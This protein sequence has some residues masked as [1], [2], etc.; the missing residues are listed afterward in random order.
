[1]KKQHK[2]YLVTSRFNPIICDGYS[3][4]PTPEASKLGSEIHEEL[5]KFFSEMLLFGEGNDSALGKMGHQ[6]LQ[7]SFGNY[8]Q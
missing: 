3:P 7:T 8:K 1:M 2:E 4:T 6:I 5:E